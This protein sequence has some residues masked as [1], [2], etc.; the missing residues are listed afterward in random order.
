MQGDA[1]TVLVIC[2]WGV[3][4]QSTTGTTECI[5]SEAKFVNFK[6]KIVTANIWSVLLMLQRVPKL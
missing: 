2:Q 1:T 3:L 5:L 6:L 4:V